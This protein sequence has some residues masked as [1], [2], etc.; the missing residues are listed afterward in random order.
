LA[1]SIQ[2]LVI[3]NGIDGDID[4]RT[5]AMGIIT[6]LADIIDAVAYGCPRAKTGS[7]D[8][9]CISPMVYG[10]NATGQILGGS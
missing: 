3:Y 5:K 1:G 8:I 6:E 10:S 4:F 7:A 2:F 9:D